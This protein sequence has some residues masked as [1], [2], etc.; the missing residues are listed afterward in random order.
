MPERPTFGTS[1][2]DHPLQPQ[3]REA[4]ERSLNTRINQIREADGSS[5]DAEGE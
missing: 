5:T 2:Q 3:R 1:Q 4:W